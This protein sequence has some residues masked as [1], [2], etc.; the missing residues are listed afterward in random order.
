MARVEKEMEEGRGFTAWI[1]I[2]V[3]AEDFYLC[4]F[5]FIA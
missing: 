5:F 4:S 3:R 1:F 2:V